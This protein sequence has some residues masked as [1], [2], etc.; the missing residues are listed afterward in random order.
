MWVTFLSVADTT[1]HRKGSKERGVREQWPV[2]DRE[3]KPFEQC[4]SKCRKPS[5]AETDKRANK[6]K[7]KD[8]ISHGNTHSRI[9]IIQI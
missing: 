8:F 6:H 1:H 5:T 7:C 3:D 9:D 4:Q 2:R